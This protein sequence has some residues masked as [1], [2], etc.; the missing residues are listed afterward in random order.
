MNELYQRTA[1]ALTKAQNVV[2]TAHIN[3]DGD[4]VGSALGL[5]HALKDAG[6]NVRVILP[7]PAPATMKWMPGIEVIEVFS[8]EPMLTLD[9]ADTIV[10]LDLNSVARLKELGDLIVRSRLDGKCTIINIDHHTE[11]EPFADVQLVDTT[12][13]ATC[14]MIVDVFKYMQGVTVS[15][16]CA[17][18]LYT[19]IMTDTGSFHFPRT[20]S[21][22]H[23][24]VAS[25]IDLGADPVAIYDN[26]YNHSPASR[27]RML[28]YALSTMSTHHD[29]KLCTMV[30]EKADLDR[31]GCTI[32][33]VEGFVHNTLE[34][35]GVEIGVLLVEAPGEIKCSFRSKG[36]V[37]VNELAKKY[38]G[39]GHIYA[40]GA[41]VKNKS[42]LEVLSSVIDE[43]WVALSANPTS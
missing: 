43:A 24:N 4:A 31:Y 38:G 11:P 20:T 5:Y 40:A 9:G 23:R 26:V 28:G 41:R 21:E 19:G 14:Q 16:V 6:K 32:D 22:L 17:T 13:A 15:E 36:S 27:M 39:G 2:I 34:I 42:L 7:T 18:C 33:D 30:V 25:L 12:A 8:L 35:D 29:G 1:D 10:V 3:P 37:F